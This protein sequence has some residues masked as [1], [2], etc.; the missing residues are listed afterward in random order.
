MKEGEKE[1]KRRKGGKGIGGQKSEC[2]RGQ[3]KCSDEIGDERR[4]GEGEGKGGEKREG[5]WGKCRRLGISLRREGPPPN[6]C[7]IDDCYASW[8]IA[9]RGAE[10]KLS[11]KNFLF[12]F[13]KYVLKRN[14]E[15]G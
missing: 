13:L 12:F 14:I 10:R 1:Q 15:N 2:H 11:K 9:R 4:R 3:N 7:D 6:G 8:I 5:M